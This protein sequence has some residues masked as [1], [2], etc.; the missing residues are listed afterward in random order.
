MSQ[1]EN[2]NNEN[3]KININNNKPIIEGLQFL[4]NKD[5]NTIINSNS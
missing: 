4:K 2:N 1:K 5:N 3:N